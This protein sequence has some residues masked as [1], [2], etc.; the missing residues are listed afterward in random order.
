[1]ILSNLNYTVGNMVK[2]T[3]E[4]ELLKIFHCKPLANKIVTITGIDYI[5]YQESISNGSNKE[6]I[7]CYRTNYDFFIAEKLIT[8]LIKDNDIITDFKFTIPIKYH[9]PNLLPLERIEGKKSDWIDL[10]AAENVVMKAGELKNISLGISMQLP[11]GYEAHVLPRSSTAKNF[12][13]IMANNVGIIDNSYNGDN[14]VWGFVAYAIRD[15]TIHVN[16]RI[17]QFRIVKNQPEI[18]FKTV[19]YLGNSDRGGIGSTG[20]V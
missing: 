1:M 12:G 2:I 5:D 11:T 13:I 4:E 14:D 3:G 16:N 17:A 6:D 20:I 10:R 19:K 15:T 18:N 7:L 9:N 8:E